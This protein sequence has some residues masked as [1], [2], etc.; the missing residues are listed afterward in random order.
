[1]WMFKLLAKWTCYTSLDNTIQVFR[2]FCRNN[3]PQSIIHSDLLPRKGIIDLPHIGRAIN[4]LQYAQLFFPTEYLTSLS[5]CALVH[6]NSHKHTQSQ[7]T[8]AAQTFAWVVLC[9]DDVFIP[10]DLLCWI[11]RHL[12]KLL[13][14]R[15][16][17]LMT[18]HLCVRVANSKRARETER[19]KTDRNRVIK[20]MHMCRFSWVSPDLYR[21]PYWNRYQEIKKKTFPQ[22]QAETR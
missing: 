5:M 13:N 6:V 1:M 3:E 12:V 7:F 8:Q 20:Q 21:L 15:D 16:S 2:S 9:R 4:I 22:N 19:T 11:K 17:A 18:G 14:L 10:D